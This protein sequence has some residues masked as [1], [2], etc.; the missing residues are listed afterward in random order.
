MSC[1]TASRKCSEAE[2]CLNGVRCVA[3]AGFEALGIDAATVRLK[4]SYATAV[5]DEDLMPGVYTVRV[6]G[7]PGPERVLEGLVATPT[8]EGELAVA[9]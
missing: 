8:P 5:R 9:F 6:S 4:T 3:R 2:T 1:V 7:Q